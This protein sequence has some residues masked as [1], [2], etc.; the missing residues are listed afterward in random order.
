V[1]ILDDGFQYRQLGRCCD[2]VL[3]PAEGLGNGH[4]IP[5]GPLREPVA[6]LKRSDIIV[7]TGAGPAESLGFGREWRWQSRP[8]P[9]RNITDVQA[10]APNEVLAVCGIA[11]P[12]RFTADLESVGLRVSATRFFPDHHTYSAEDVRT[13]LAHALPVVVTGKDAVKLRSLWP[14]N[15]PL[16]VLRQSA[17]AE[18]GLLMAIMDRLGPKTNTQGAEGMGEI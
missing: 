14:K 10:N 3:V 15:S 18:K 17:E 1:L 6:A 16:W 12:E 7:R 4:Q 8:G 5:A 13:I 9:L 11:R 2:I